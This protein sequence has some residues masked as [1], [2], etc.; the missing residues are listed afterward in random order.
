MDINILALL[1]VLILAGAMF[2]VPKWG[3]HFSTSL[4]GAILIAFGL[5]GFYF[6]NFL[7]IGDQPLLEYVKNSFLIIFSSVGANF[8]VSGTLMGIKNKEERAKTKSDECTTCL[9]KNLVSPQVS[10]SNKQE[11]I[12]KLLQTNTRQRQISNI[13]ILLLAA[14]VTLLVVNKKSSHGK[15]MK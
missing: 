13:S 10:Q 3:N 4:V 8:L 12:A 14:S 5:A 2:F 15:N 11:D 6:S 9:P 7:S 1:G